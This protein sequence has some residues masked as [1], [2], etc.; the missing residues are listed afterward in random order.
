MKYWKVTYNNPL[1][2]MKQTFYFSIEECP[3]KIYLAVAIER[4]KKEY[5]LIDK[6]ITITNEDLLI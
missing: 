6:Y 3:N 2:K 1:E 4:L 5:N